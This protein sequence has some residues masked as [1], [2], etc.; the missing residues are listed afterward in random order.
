MSPLASSARRVL[1]VDDYVDSRYVTCVALGLRGHTCDHVGTARA[2]F[3]SLATFR[4]D[5][6]LLEWALRD[7]S[8]RG[9]SL[10]LR[11][12]SLELGVVLRVIAVSSQNEPAGLALAEGFDHYM[13]KPVSM[14]ELDEV[15]RATG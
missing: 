15:L 7:G 2:A 9:L 4:P 8:G 14:D 13:T 12:A 6:V 1:V 11:R 10:R 5:V 3:S